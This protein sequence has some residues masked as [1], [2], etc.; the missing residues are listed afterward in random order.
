MTVPRGNTCEGVNSEILAYLARAYN[1]GS[2]FSIL[3][4]PCGDGEFLD[5]VLDRFPISQT[6]G[7]DIITPPGPFRHTF[8]HF[9]AARGDLP[10]TRSFDIVTCISGVMEFDNTLAFFERIKCLMSPNG[11]LMVTNDNLLSVKDRLLYFI[12]GRFGQY[13]FNIAKGAAT[14]K[15]IPAQNMVRILIDAGFEISE[16]GYVPVRPADWMWIFLALPLYVL[17]RVFASGPPDG[18]KREVFQL[19]SFLSRHYV[20]ICRPVPDL[21]PLM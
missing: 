2:R 9:D 5:A 7:A 1:P 4:V 21:P 14:W 13:P 17:Q 8:L 20:I 3:D 10:A 15:I 11:T 16:I 6:T 12:S 18:V 19:R